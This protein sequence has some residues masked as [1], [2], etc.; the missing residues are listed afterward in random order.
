MQFSVV[1]QNGSCLE[2]QLRARG[3]A[4]NISLYKV[5]VQGEADQVGLRSVVAPGAH[6]SAAQ[7]FT[8][9]SYDGLYLVVIIFLLFVLV[10]QRCTAGGRGH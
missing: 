5:I 1:V 9:Q 3:F 7:G 10:R 4:G 8:E 2:P 6:S